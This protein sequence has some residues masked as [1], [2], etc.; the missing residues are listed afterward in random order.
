MTICRPGKG[1]LVIQ[2]NTAHIPDPTGVQPTPNRGAN[3]S[4]SAPSA[5]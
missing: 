5:P 2:F 3:P 1:H 4:A